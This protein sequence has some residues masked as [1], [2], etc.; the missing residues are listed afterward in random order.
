M[1]I[2][3]L[4]NVT[5]SSATAVWLAPGALS[6]MHVASTTGLHDG[7][8]GAAVRHARHLRHVNDSR[9]ILAANRKALHSSGVQPTPTACWRERAVQVCRLLANVARASETAQDSRMQSG[10]R[11]TAVT[12]GL[13][14]TSAHCRVAA[15]SAPHLYHFE[16]AQQHSGCAAGGVAARVV[17]WQHPARR[18]VLGGG[19]ACA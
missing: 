11:G 4:L 10:G 13:V 5:V 3:L 6:S 18:K 12:C 17:R 7:G 8:E 19:Q 16:H 1:L 2:W 14:Y 9:A 15:E